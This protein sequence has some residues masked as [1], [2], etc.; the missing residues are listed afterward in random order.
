MPH[1]LI[2]KEEIKENI[3]YLSD[4]DNFFHITKVLRSKVGQKIKFTDYKQEK[5]FPYWNF[6]KYSWY[7][8]SRE[9][10]L[11]LRILSRSR[12]VAT[13]FD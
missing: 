9:L 10:S 4:N 13:I 8:S 12:K 3:I 2:K 5:S 1:F 6:A 11:L 7:S